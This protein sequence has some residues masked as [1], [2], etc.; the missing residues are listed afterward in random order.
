MKTKGIIAAGH[1]ETARAAAIILEEGGN[2]FDAALAAMCAACIAEP[3]LASLGGGGF[4]LAQ[5]SAKPK[6]P[7]LYD[8]FVQTPKRRHPADDVDFTPVFADFGEVQQEFHIGLGSLATPGT[9]A[10]LFAVHEDLASMPMAR[11]IEPA[12]ALA[13]GGVRINALQAYIFTVVEKI[14]TSNETC[15]AAYAG[16]GTPQRLLVEGETLKSPDFANVLDAL[17]REGSDLFYLGEIADRLVGNCREQGG[18]LSREDLEGYEVIRRHPLKINYQDTRILT[19]PPPSTGGVLI[20]FALALLEGQKLGRERFGSDRYLKQM[21]QVMEMTNE[22]R[23]KSRLHEIQDESVAATLLDRDFIELYRARIAGH[24]PAHRGTTHI[25]IIDG[26]G[27]V[28]SLTLSNGEGSAYIIPGTGIMVNNMLGE[29][30]INPRG[31]HQWPKDTR[32]CSMMAPSLMQHPEGKLTAIG[33]GGSNRIRTAILQV[34]V[35]L[36]EFGMTI[37][38][39]VESPRL[40]VEGD[41]LSIESGFGE[42]ATGLLSKD[43]PEIKEWKDRNMFFGGVHTVSFEP[44]KGR[45]E[46]VGDPRRGGITVTV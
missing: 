4:M 42:Q 9:V 34:L 45:M 22:A 5:S 44:R 38:Q 27:N 19:N 15:L 29:E 1:E 35:N 14:F 20:A 37:E 6:N 36:I 13:S 23:V 16:P 31:F 21:A 30:D 28:A 8:F 41:L 39:A 43:F 2:A 17:A 11:I 33:S 10:G 7:V 18:C 3:V 12:L 24:P 32:M 25:S 26:K 40:H 46:G